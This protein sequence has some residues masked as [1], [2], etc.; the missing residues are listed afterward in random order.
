MK[1][2]CGASILP[3][4]SLSLVKAVGEDMRVSQLISKVTIDI[5]FHEPHTLSQSSQWEA[6]DNE[7]YLRTSCYH[8]GSGMEEVL[9]NTVVSVDTMLSRK[10]YPHAF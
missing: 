5:L 10:K 9:A 7:L 6:H 8:G 2:C 1:L 3:L 4:P